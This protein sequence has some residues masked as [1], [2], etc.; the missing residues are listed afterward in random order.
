MPIEEPESM[1]WIREV[2]KKEYEETKDMTP[3]EQIAYDRAKSEDIMK[4]YKLKLK[5]LTKTGK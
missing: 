5:V 1:K 3:E 4:R 2:R